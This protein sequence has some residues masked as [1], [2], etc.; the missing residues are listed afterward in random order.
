MNFFRSLLRWTCSV[1]V[2]CALAAPAT[3]QVTVVDAIPNTMSNESFNNTEPF[4]AIDPTNPLT[5]V[6]SP[7]MLT[8][9]GS[10]N[11][12]LLVSFDGGNTWVAR[13][14]IPGC[15]GCLNTGDI[16]I[17]YVSAN[18]DFYAGILSALGGMRVLR[19]TDPTLATVFS[20]LSNVSSR[21]QPYTNART[22][23]GWYD[24]GKERIWV[25]NNNAATSPKSSTVDQSLDAAIAMP[26][27]TSIGIDVDSPVGRDNYQTRPVSHADGHV[28][29]AFYRRTGPDPAGYTAD[30]VVVRDDNWGKNMPPFQ[31]LLDSVSSIAGQRVVSNK[32]ITDD[33]SG[34]FGNEIIGGDLFLTVDPNNSANV[35]ISWADKFMGNTMTLHV[36]RST[37]WGQTWGPN[38]LLTVPSAKN[39]ALA[40][41]SQGKIAYAYQQLT[42]T[43]PNRHWQ[44]HLRRSVDGVTWDDT[45]LSDFFAEGANAPPGFRIIGDYDGLIAVG[46]NFYGV[47]SADNDLV[48][49]TFPA[50]VTFQRNHNATQFL[51]NDGVTPVARSVDPFFYWTMELNPASDFYVRDWTDSMTSYDHGAEPS[52]H[53]NFF[54]F[55]DVWNRRTNDPDVF[56]ANNRPQ[57]Q[58]PQP[59]AMGHNYAFA[60]V[61][62]EVNGTPTTVNLHFLYSD[63]G[64]GVNFVDAGMTDPTVH[65]SNVNLQKQL[66]A[67]NGYQWELPSGA[68]N[69]VCLAVEIYTAADPLIPPSLVG[70]APGWPG[71]DLMIVNDNNKAQRNMQVLGFGGM[72][73][74]MGMSAYLIAHNAATFERDMQIGIDVDPAILRR[75][76]RPQAQTIGGPSDKLPRPTPITPHSLVTL[77]KMLPG[78]NRWIEVK[79]DALPG[80]VSGPMPI[81]FY[82]VVNNVIVNGYSVAPQALSA[83]AA[84]RANLAQHAAVFSRLQSAF[85]EERAKRQVIAAQKVL[86]QKLVSPAAYLAFLKQNSAAVAEL[87]RHFVEA[88]RVEDP[89]QAVAAAQR[90]ATEKKIG[91]ALADHLTLLNKLDATQTMIQKAKGD[92]ADILQMVRWQRELYSQVPQL[93]QL[94]GSALVVKESQGF[95]AAFGKR[96]RKA[97]NYPELM[98]ELLKSF[99]ETA[100]ALAKAG[101]DAKNEVAAIEHDLGSLSAL[102][103]AHRD[104]LLKLQ[105]VAK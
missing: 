17:H 42:G 38:D 6:I 93:K 105:S 22:V 61:S 2:V 90:L 56:D 104:Y 78:E 32:P 12:P 16:T 54:D 63:G 65:F 23:F 9:M 103:K 41:N 76:R 68:S 39:G 50:G 14:V 29:A 11:G 80:Q 92:P 46:K 74:A 36:Q 102:E 28:Y 5:I 73:G 40:V 69:H 15:S 98:R 8:P 7:F 26:T 88:S 31:N 77:P 18:S 4:I 34:S 64:V 59:T 100:D 33:F 25:G 79:L 82:E 94:P 70:H 95:I 85:G 96:E 10:S 35:Y 75:I 45:L 91:Q 27:I 52:T 20:S 3:A 43:V 47:F 97:D 83:T 1:V 99:H 66:T 44:T 81:R 48:N 55:S 30:V 57:N 21:D 13:N 101:V 89:F 49:A 51:G 53:A 72:S 71:T 19:S 24:P 84:I 86:K 37:D 58:D 62:R 87:S 67:G 60:R